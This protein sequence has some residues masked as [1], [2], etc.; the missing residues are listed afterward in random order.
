MKFCV[1]ISGTE[2]VKLLAEAFL[3]PLSNVTKLVNNV[4]K[5][6]IRFHPILGYFDAVQKDELRNIIISIQWSFCIWPV[7]VLYSVYSR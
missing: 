7:G 2:K 4:T 5:Q 1:M 3:R 6:K